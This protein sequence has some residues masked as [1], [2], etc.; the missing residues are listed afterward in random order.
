MVY[1]KVDNI[2]CVELGNERFY[3]E[4]LRDIFRFVKKTN[5]GLLD[6]LRRMI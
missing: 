5:S 3:S 4:E 2:H 1:Y 6:S